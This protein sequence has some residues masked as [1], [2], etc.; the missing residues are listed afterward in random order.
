MKRLYILFTHFLPLLS[1]CCFSILFTQRMPVCISLVECQHFSENKKNAR[2][3]PVRRSS[4]IYSLAHHR[5]PQ[6]VIVQNVM[7][8]RRKKMIA[9]SRQSPEPSEMCMPTWMQTIWDKIVDMKFHELSRYV[10][11]VDWHFRTHIHSFE[12]I[13]HRPHARAQ[14]TA[15]IPTR[16]E[17]IK[18]TLI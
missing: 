8:Q 2:L 11:T 13:L 10:W 4:A 17:N 6:R 1:I 14:H 9:A 16:I 5:A 18:H 7:K 3:C 12:W 15:E